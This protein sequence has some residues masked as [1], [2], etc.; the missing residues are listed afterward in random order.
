MAA[1]PR[2]PRARSNVINNTFAFNTVGLVLTNTTST[3]LQAYVASNIFWENHDQ[4]NAR[5]GF[6]IFS[7]NPN[8]VSLQNNLFSG[9]GASETSQANA[10]NDLGNG[11]NPALLG[12]LAA[13][14]A[15]NLG[16]FTGN[17]AFAYPIDPRP[18]SDGP[19]NFFI[20]ADFQLTSS[21][22][23]DRQRLGSHGDPNG[24]AR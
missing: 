14:A 4:T 13:N 11:F 12:P 15:S 20:S 8:K 23:G 7:T 10:T 9:N 17:P 2:A 18:G 22:G 16:N 19:A 3:P 1:R 21:F 24:L 6:A 5:N